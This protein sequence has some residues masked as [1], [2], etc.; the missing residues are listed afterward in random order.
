MSISEQKSALRQKV[1]LLLGRLSAEEVAA[2]S[3]AIFEQVERLEEFKKAKHILAYSSLATEVQTHDF[4]QKWSGEKNIFLPIV[5]GDE[6]LVGKLPAAFCHCGLDPQSSATSLRGGTTMHS[7]LDWEIAGQA[8]NDKEGIS[9]FRKGVFGI[10]EPADALAEMPPLDLAIIPGL[11]FDRQ[12]NRLGRGKG[13][14]DK[15]LKMKDLQKIGVCFGCQ[16]FDEI[17]HE[18]FD[19]RMDKVIHD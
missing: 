3:A 12:N 4:L 7:H 8:R 5:H 2:K 14:Y 19:V 1:K 11:A 16:L 15:F 17:L 6:L 9:A 10:L 18:E 13:Y